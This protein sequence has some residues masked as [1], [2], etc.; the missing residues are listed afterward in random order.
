MSSPSIRRTPLYDRHVAAGGKL[1]EFAGWEMP[2]QYRGVIDEHRA[3]R[4]AAG[5]FDVSH[6]GQ[7]RVAGPSAEAFVQHLTP[8]DVTKLAPGRAHYSALLSLEA[9]FLDD[10]LVYRMAADEFILVVN[11]SN[12][13]FDF[14]WVAS[15]PHDG[16][17]VE[18]VSDHYALIA[19]Q[20]PKA[21]AILQP[22]TATPLGADPLLRLRARRGPGPSGDPVAHRLHRRGRLRALP[23][24]R[25]WRSRSGIA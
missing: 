23:R 17:A 18:N 25:R 5:L 10:L 12:A 15:Q 6:M 22:L 14:A 20:G 8:N 16:L 9:T 1:V 2:V 21:V 24:A 4:T 3:V 19:I 11:A 13:E 7:I